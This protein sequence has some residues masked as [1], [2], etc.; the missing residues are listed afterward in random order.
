MEKPNFAAFFFVPFS[1]NS[2]SFLTRSLPQLLLSLFEVEAT[3]SIKGA[4][5]PLRNLKRK[6][7][8]LNTKSTSSSPT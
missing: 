6:T 7:K 5:I 4:C 1:S 8:S 3:H 2:L